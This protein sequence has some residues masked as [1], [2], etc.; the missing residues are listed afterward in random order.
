MKKFNKL[1]GFRS[2]KKWKKILASC[3]Y[4]L[5]IIFFLGSIFEVPE[6]KA[7]MYDMFIYK[8]SMILFGIS[9]LAPTILLSN[10]E[11]KNK[12]PLF[13]KNKW[14]S[15]TL[16]FVIVILFAFLC[17][18]VVTVFHS[19]DF[20]ER[21][22]DYNSTK[23]IYTSQESDEVS[24]KDESSLSNEE[25]KD[26]LEEIIEENKQND[27]KN[28]IDNKD[29]SSKKE[30][31]GDKTTN[32]II[33]DNDNKTTNEVIDNTDNK[34]DNVINM[35]IHYIDVG[36]GDAIFIE[37]PNSNTMLIDAGE[38]S[39]GQVVANYIKSLEY[40]KIDYLIGTH[41]HTDHIGGLAQVINTFTIG[42]IYMPKAVST[43]K[44][45]ENL[46]N[47]ISAKG[48][49]IHNATAG[50]NI[51][52]D[53]N[54]KIDIL[55]PNN[56]S[57]SNLN[58]YSVVLKINYKDKKFLFTGDIETLSENEIIADLSADV[59]KVAHHGSDSSSGISFVN[60]VKPQYA[61]FSVGTNNRYNHPVQ[62]IIERWQNIGA[63][64]YR[65]DLNGTII[66]TTDGITIDVKTLR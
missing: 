38:S 5:G 13:R 59:V 2:N 21:Y 41:P 46:L 29:D 9:F 45:Y 66:V 22:N 39:K 26:N 1:L 40:S 12:I 31:T 48:L 10:I 14:W 50:I 4:I 6:I 16:G 35:K 53:N 63:K 32:E 19:N 62:I 64:I 8:T 56:D 15:N 49:K 65:T 36:Q 27:E 7:N 43:S 47:T 42:E 17:S 54:L 18:D 11:F 55:A 61:I 60:K 57:Y 23:I 34:I 30:S 52:N 44:T 33:E 51:I 24:K 37:L 20:K 3:Y 58:N 28:D 25:L